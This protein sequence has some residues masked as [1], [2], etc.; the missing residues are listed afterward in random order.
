MFN[1]GG[2]TDY[3][4]LHLREGNVTQMN[5]IKSMH[6]KA[7]RRHFTCVIRG[8][9]FMHPAIMERYECWFNF[10]DAMHSSCCYIYLYHFNISLLG[11]CVFFSTKGKPFYGLCKL[12]NHIH[13]HD[14]SGV[15]VQAK[16]ALTILCAKLQTSVFNMKLLVWDF[17]ILVGRY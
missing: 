6:G 12:Q 15:K 14:M 13:V 17:W 7:P 4:L 16:V 11:I 10:P 5:N 8:M 1:F 9:I 3:P 2:L